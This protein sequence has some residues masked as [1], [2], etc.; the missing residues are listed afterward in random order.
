V[1]Q[2]TTDFVNLLASYDEA[3][4][5]LVAKEFAEI[6][7]EEGNVD[8]V[9]SVLAALSPQIKNEF[10]DRVARAPS[11]ESEWNRL[12]IFGAGMDEAACIKAKI[13][14]RLC[15]ERVRRETTQSK[16]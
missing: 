9:L 16:S 2:R 1:Y 13:T 4:K 14:W 7:I 5:R 12:Q 15:V 6:F 8:E 10:L 11:S 3:D